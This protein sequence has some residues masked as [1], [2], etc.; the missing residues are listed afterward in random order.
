MD[1]LDFGSGAID[2]LHG[3][4]AEH[5]GCIHAGSEGNIKS[6]LMKTLKHIIYRE[7]STRVRR[8]A[9]WLGTLLIPAL[10]AGSIGL[11]IWMDSGTEKE[12]KVL[13]VDASGLISRFDDRREVWLPTHPEIGRAHV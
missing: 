5:A 7:W 8:K 6:C 11:G 10:L 12:A 1:P 2:L 4:A 9:F 13:V 3:M